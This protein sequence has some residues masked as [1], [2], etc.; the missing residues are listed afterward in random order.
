[1]LFTENNVPRCTALVIDSFE[2]IEKKAYL[3]MSCISP[4]GHAVLEKTQGEETHSNPCSHIQSHFPIKSVT[5]VRIL[6]DHLP[7]ADTFTHEHTY[8]QSYRV[9]ASTC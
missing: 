6:T 2:P 3:C 5:H 8:S 7:H 4:C 9:F 1:M